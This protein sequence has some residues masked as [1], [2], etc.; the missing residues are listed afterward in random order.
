MEKIKT[1]NG[2][3]S[4][5]MPIPIN[6]N[7]YDQIS[8][9]NLP[10]LLERLIKNPEIISEILSYL[11]TFSLLN[12]AA[13]NQAIRHEILLPSHPSHSRLTKFLQYKTVIC[14]MAEFENLSSFIT[15]YRVF[16]PCHL[17]FTYSTT[18]N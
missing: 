9:Q 10:T 6:H 17:H 18:S 3:W 7:G 13:T 14:P 2:S 4:L 11:D 12:F 16:K 8:T 1:I 15:K 5:L